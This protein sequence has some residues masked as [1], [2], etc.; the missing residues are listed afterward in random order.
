[1]TLTSTAPDADRKDAMADALRLTREG[2]LTE[3]TALLQ[4]GLQG[5]GTAHAHP[6]PS[7]RA[8]A[9]PATGG[10][11]RGLLDRLRSR[12]PNA[13]GGLGAAA[14]SV[15][16]AAGPVGALP[17]GHGP[18]RVAAADVTAGAAVARDDRGA[19]GGRRCRRRDPA[20]GAHVGGGV[21]GVRPVRPHRVH[22]G[23]GAARRHAARG[24]QDA[25]DFAAGTRLNDLAERHT[26]LVAY[27]EQTPRRTA[28]AT[29]TGSAPVTSSGTPGSRPSSPASPAR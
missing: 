17:A 10:A 7:G 6:A 13:R 18:T 25:A 4:Q 22:R 15:R 19:A 27:P 1:M 28:G 21:A 11:A 3:A 16:A 5:H 20:T 29:G 8:A 24:T 14:G 12:L 26:L 2:R 23:T 9:E